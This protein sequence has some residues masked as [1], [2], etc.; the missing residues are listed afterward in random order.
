MKAL[1][2][3]LVS[4]FFIQSFLSEQLRYS[5][6]RDARDVKDSSLRAEF[7]K[8]DLSYPPQEIFFQAFKEEGDLELWVRDSDRDKFELFKTYE[9]V[10]KSGVLGPKTKQGDLQVPEGCYHIDRYNPS[11]LFHLSLGINYPNKAD[12]RS[13]PGANWGGD[14]FIH[15]SNVTIGCLPMSDDR[16]KEIYWLAVQAKN[17]NGAQTQV[18]IFPY[19]MNSL[20]TLYYETLYVNYPKMKEFWRQLKPIYQ[21][22]QENRTIPQ[23]IINSDGTYGLE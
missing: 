1:I 8:K 2:V 16:I 5:R 3:C 22:F 14:I 13:N 19:R 7:E 15:G 11:S 21:S 6:V 17:K 10:T 12:K 23:V 18:H 9:I 20:N 4:V